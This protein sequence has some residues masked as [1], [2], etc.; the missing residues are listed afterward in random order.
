LNELV[1]KHEAY[2]R[3]YTPPV[4]WDTFREYMLYLERYKHVLTY[5]QKR[6]LCVYNPAKLRRL[7]D[8]WAY[9]DEVLVRKRYARLIVSPPRKIESKQNDL[10]L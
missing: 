5:Y 9:D 2:K 8:G 6:R 7:A 4:W 1:R 3:T 10:L